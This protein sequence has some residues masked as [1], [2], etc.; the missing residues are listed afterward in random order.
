MLEMLNYELTGCPKLNRGT[1]G[2]SATS[3]LSILLWT[4]FQMLLA[5]SAAN[6]FEINSKLYF[7]QCL[8]SETF[9]LSICLRSQS[10]LGGTF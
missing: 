4:K 3:D 2:I 7:V 1:F 10:R 9:Y 6:V 8:D 5:S